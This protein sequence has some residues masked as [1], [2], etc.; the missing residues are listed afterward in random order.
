MFRL[1]RHRFA[2]A[3]PFGSVKRHVVSRV[4]ESRQGLWSVLGGPSTCG[5][6]LLIFVG[7]QPNQTDDPAAG[8]A[9]DAAV[10]A[11][12]RLTAE[13]EPHRSVDAGSPDRSTGDD[14]VATDIERPLAKMKLAMRAGRYSEAWRYRHAVM[15]NHA[16]DAEALATI[17]E[18]AFRTGDAEA[19]ADWLLQ[20]CRA[21]DFQNVSRVEQT[22]VAMVNIGRLFNGID[23]LR[24]AVSANP[25]SDKIRRMLFDFLVGV[26]RSGEAAPHG[27]VLIRSRQFDL[28]LLLAMANTESRQMDAEVLRQMV[29]RHASDRRPIIGEARIDIDANRWSEA[30]K[31]LREIVDR[32]PADEVAAAMLAYASVMNGSSDASA[33]IFESLDISTAVLQQSWWWMACGESQTGS[34]RAECFARAAASDPNWVLPWIKWSEA[35]EEVPFTAVPG[36]SRQDVA[37]EEMRDRVQRRVRLLTRF[38][39]QR[40][41]FERT[42]KISR[43][44]VHSM[45]E[46]LGELGRWWEAEAWLAVGMTLPP[47]DSVDLVS[48]RDRVVGQ[49]GPS[50]PMQIPTVA[51]EVSA[52][53]QDLWTRVRPSLVRKSEIAATPLKSE[54]LAAES[55]AAFVLNDEA[56]SR[57]LC[58]FGRTADD[59][60]RPGIG[61]HQTLGC[62]GATIDF[63]LDG[64]HD[65][66]LAAAGGT[67]PHDDS[68]ANRLFQNRGGQFAMVVCGVE[69]RGFGQGVT[70]GDLNADGHPDLVALNYGRNRVYMN[71]GDGTFLDTSD[72]W[73]GADAESHWSTSAAVADLDGDA[74]S[75]LVVLNYCG[76][77]DPVHETCGTDAQTRSCSPMKFA[78]AS[79]QIFITRPSGSFDKRALDSAEVLGRGL[80]VLVTTL[81]SDPGNDVFIANDMTANHFWS[82]P[83]ETDGD[84]N[85]DVDRA[86]GETAEATQWRDTALIR[87][88]AVNGQSLPQGSMGIALG[89][90]DDDGQ[91]DLYVTNF[92]GEYNSMHLSG[93]GGRWRDQTQSL[94]LLR[95]T[96]PWVGFGTEAVDLD[97]D[98][99]DELMITNG[100]VDMF[101]RE[102]EASVY[103]HPLQ[104]FARDGDSPSSFGMAQV[105]G[106][107]ASRNHV[108]RALWTLDADRDGRTDVCITHQTEPVALLVNRTESRGRYLELR[109]SGTRS[110]RDAIGARVAIWHGDREMVRTVSSGDGYLCRNR[111]E[112][113][114]S[115]P[116]SV[117]LVD[118]EIT[119]PDGT[120]ERHTGLGTNRRFLIVQGDSKP[121]RMLVP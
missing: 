102:D 62:G 86:S 78:A 24:D 37:P 9:K 56:E 65:V 31:R 99:S 90:W 83:S 38:N 64:W 50:V 23:M 94:G 28:E 43:E 109:L 108:G 74:L 70:T 91:S 100:H 113:V 79:D 121:F 114:C 29:E 106:A 97:A 92:D 69:D 96:L 58:F 54:K 75:D 46:T 66:Y 2:R 12:S 8:S 25:K 15:K 7:C 115:L 71:Q 103:A 48:L 76:G 59:L 52:P 119:W 105:A 3:I 67:P 101:S 89:D 110:E 53:A 107:Y 98:G 82:R 117:R 44:I 87:G 61:L 5:W 88:L 57:G 47:D 10:V 116:E 111:P 36:R 13:G 55:K 73:F 18:A 27:E 85:S 16:E 11:K 63:D 33:K 40:H 6:M 68:E 4:V 42:G 41:R 95:P 39:Q 51:S 81:D 72:H 80:G 1:G 21:E 112:V 35:L 49:L 118:I 84:R 22:M 77:L 32:H 93:A 20:A 26:E 104:V 34:R 17:A 60:D 45:A 19:A 30:V 120:T 14:L